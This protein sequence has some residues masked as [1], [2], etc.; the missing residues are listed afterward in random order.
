M[1]NA[2]DNHLNA[3]N[4]INNKIQ[5]NLSVFDLLINFLEEILE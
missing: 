3:D 4:I 2:K 5:E 1:T